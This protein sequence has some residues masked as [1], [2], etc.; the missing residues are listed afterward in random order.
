VFHVEHDI[1]RDWK[2]KSNIDLAHEKE[3]V[4]ERYAFLICSANR[5]FN[6]TGL[7]T[8]Q[9][10][11]ADLVLGSIEP[12][13][14]LNVPRGTRFLDIGTGAGIPGIPIAV[15]HDGL[16]GVLL[17]SNG[18]KISFLKSVIQDLSLEN[19]RVLQARAEMLART[20]MRSAFDL[21]F[22]RAL[23]PLSIVAELAAPMLVLGGLLY[24]Y[25][26]ERMEELPAQMIAHLKSMGM[27]P[28]DAHERV[29]FGLADGNIAFIKTDVTPDTFPR[30]MSAI[31]GNAKR[32]AA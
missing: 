1:I 8:E 15:F 6:L 16:A 32:Y 14:H 24:V 5:R 26:H 2:L 22:S 19:V 12:L 25:S 30:R 17:D 7:K 20:G 10:I 3:N 28:L 11:L 13:I 29:R 4:L 21:V 31:K 18:K 9:D 27:S 23:A